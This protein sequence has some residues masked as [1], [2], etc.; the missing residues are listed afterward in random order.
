MFLVTLSLVLVE[1]G[2][3]KAPPPSSPSL[4]D[5]TTNSASERYAATFHDGASL[6]GNLD[7]ADAAAAPSPSPPREVPGSP[8]CPQGHVPVAVAVPFGPESICWNPVRNLDARAACQQQQQAAAAAAA[9]VVEAGIPRRTLATTLR[10][11][12]A[13]LSSIDPTHRSIDRSRHDH[14]SRG[15]AEMP[16]V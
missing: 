7:E 16:T 9:A 14:G 5:T 11:P 3:A 6:S 4:P 2:T 13:C 1:R 8:G 15:L 12:S 10:W